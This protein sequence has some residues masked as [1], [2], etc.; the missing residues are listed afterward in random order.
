MSADAGDTS[1]KIAV[2]VP[3]YNGGE[4]LRAC[5]KAITSSRRRP[6]HVVVVDDGSTDGTSAIARSFGCEPLILSDGPRGPARARN[7][8]AAQAP[9]ADILVFVDADTVV[10]PDT[11]SRIEQHLLEAPDVKALFGSYDAEPA[12]QN[13]VSLYKNLLHHYVHQVSR[14]QASTFWAGCGAVRRETFDALGGFDESYSDASVEDI[15]FGVRMHQA[16]HRILLCPDV[17][18]KHLKRWTLRDLIYTDIFRRAI[19]WSRL[20]LQ[21]GRILNDLNL[22][23]AHRVAAAAAVTLILSALWAWWKPGPAMSLGGAA[24]LVFVVCNLNLLRFFARRRGMP[25][26]FAA[27]GLHL[28]YY[29][30]ST[31][32]LTWVICRTAA[33]RLRG[34]L[35]R[36][37][38]AVS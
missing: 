26:T 23:I 33:E 29:L 28:V 4:T 21:E 16:G 20:L 19:P 2:I 17:Q 12:A 38:E 15:E 1:V 24:V 30:Y 13:T 7:R 3:V 31:T 34:R 32:A 27:S 5:L 8:G 11:L 22:K 10:H 9:K 6:D 35:T 18:A 37:P 36:A 14:R 25:F